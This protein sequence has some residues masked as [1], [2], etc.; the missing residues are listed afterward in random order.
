ML[1]ASPRG[2]VRCAPAG[3]HDIV[4][5]PHSMTGS[6]A[7][8]WIAVPS[9]AESRYVVPVPTDEARAMALV[10]SA[11]DGRHRIRAG[12]ILLHGGVE[13]SADSRLP[14]VRES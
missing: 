5:H 13:Q 4:H 14:V 7:A 2:E 3:M 8:M 10:Q 9:M 6:H 12:A 1:A 11:N